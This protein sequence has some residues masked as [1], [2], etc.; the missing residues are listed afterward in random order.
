SNNHGLVTGDK[1]IV[2]N[3]ADTTVPVVFIG[4]GNTASKG[5][6]HVTVLNANQFVLT[7]VV[8][9][10]AY[11]GGS[12]WQRVD[13]VLLRSQPLVT[14]GSPAPAQGGLDA[15]NGTVDGWG[16]DAALAQ[17]TG[18]EYVPMVVNEVVP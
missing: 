6:W 5:T 1:V 16:T 17:G 11:T 18:F 4:G 3:N 7:N 2:F 10:G 15:V 9:N 12:F 14:A 13:T 8:G